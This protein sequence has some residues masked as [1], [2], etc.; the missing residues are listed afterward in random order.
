[1]LVAHA[2]LHIH[3]DHL[4]HEPFSSVLLPSLLILSVW[5]NPAPGAGALH[6][7][8]YNSMK[9]LLTQSSSFQSH[10]RLNLCSLAGHPLPWFIG[11]LVVF[12]TFS[13]YNWILTFCITKGILELFPKHFSVKIP[14]NCET[15]KEQVAFLKKMWCG[16]EVTAISIAVFYSSVCID[17]QV[18]EASVHRSCCLVRLSLRQEQLH[19]IGLEKKHT[20]SLCELSCKGYKSLDCKTSMWEVKSIKNS[21]W[22][23]YFLWLKTELDD[24][25][26]HRRRHLILTKTIYRKCWTLI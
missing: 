23:C 22:S 5:G 4:H 26:L 6:L 2:Q 15:Y 14:N 1:M 18:K 8:S 19:H 9:F 11:S 12:I 3:C 16:F 17:H 25:L 24:H 21:Q 7:C 20:Y 13:N 10:S